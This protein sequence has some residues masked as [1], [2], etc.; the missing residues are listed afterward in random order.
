[1]FLGIDLGTSN[2]VIYGVMDNGSP[3]LFK[4]ADGGDTL[5]SVIYVDKRGARLYG[6]RAQDQVLLNPDSV[7]HGFKRL[8]GTSTPIELSGAG[9][10]LTPAECSADIIKQLLAQAA[11]ETG[12]AEVEGVVVTIPA[13]FNQMQS[14]AT[15]RAVE[16]AGITAS[17]KLLQEP[18]AAAIAA[19]H[20]D[21]RGQFLIYDLGG[22][23]FDL[24]LAKADNKEIKI[25]A[26]QGINMLGGRDF[27]R[28]LVQDIIRPW[29]AENFSLPEDFMRQPAYRR[30]LRVAQ[31]A[32]EKAKI[33]LSS[34]ESVTIFA[35]DSEVRSED[36]AGSDIFLDVKVTRAQFEELIADT[37]DRTVAVAQGLLQDQGLNA[38]DIDHLVFVGGP[39]KIPLV[40]EKVASA[41]GLKADLS[42]DPM[43]TVAMGAAYYAAQMG[44]KA[45]AV[46]GRSKV[47]GER[48]PVEKLQITEEDTAEEKKPV[49]ITPEEAALT[50]AIIEPAPVGETP[51]VPLVTIPA[52]KTIAVKV[53]DAAGEQNSLIPI[54]EAGTTL[55]ATGTQRFTAGHAIG[56][57]HAGTLSFELFQLEFPERLELNLCIGAFRIG[58]D[59][60]PDDALVSEGDALEFHWHMNDSGILTAN[61]SIP[62]TNDKVIRLSSPRF[63]APQEGERSYAGALA[64]EFAAAVLRQGREELGD[65]LAALGPMASR[66]ID[67]LRHRLDEQEQALTESV[68]DPELMR[69]VS[70]EARFIR[71]DLA[72]LSRRQAAAV[73]QR[74]LGRLMAAYNRAA[75]AQATPDEIAEFDRAVAQINEIVAAANARRAAAKDDKPA[76]GTAP[77]AASAARDGSIPVDEWHRAERSLADLRR[78]FFAGAWRNLEYVA[79]WLDTARQESYLFPDQDEYR[80]LMAEADKARAANDNDKFRSVM[81]KILAARVSLGASG[82]TADLA[83]IL[84]G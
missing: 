78:L 48:P 38:G 23:T 67:L 70:E 19:A 20:G 18:V 72:R 39:S 22:G 16:R 12:N 47:A 29:L 68:D 35:S 64:Q 76:V 61:V 7:A 71:Q 79:L 51:S 34:R 37:V 44:G 77:T 26:N 59:D 14:E 24:A 2:S 66:E 54:L 56:V 73:L 5:P 30:L 50:T 25:V 81:G 33:E 60:L 84:Q 63:Y 11:T 69:Q 43:T 40:R 6:R 21:I 65:V 82:S 57:G 17:V 31:L 27:D 13:A 28:R 4:T 45:V 3:R 10:S 41:L 49:E 52:A 1:M 80:E 42:M 36:S 8:M 83:T 32:A 15:L 53:R 55:P 75:R 9:I 58:A 74:R 46:A 62:T